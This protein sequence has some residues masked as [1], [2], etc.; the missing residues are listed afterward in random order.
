VNETILE[1]LAN[2][3]VVPWYALR[4]KSNFEKVSATLLTERG[5]EVF[6][7]T[8]HSRRTWSD[9]VVHLDLPLFPGYV[10][11]RVPMQNRVKVLSTP[12]VVSL[13][14][15]GKAPTAIE[16]S[17]IAAVRVL[18]NSKLSTQPWPFLQIGQRVRITRG[19]LSGVEG[20]LVEFKS[21]YRLVV[22]VSLLQRSVATEVDGSLVQPVGTVLARAAGVA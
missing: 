9:R 1:E 16:E 6:L 17:E 5:L 11:C 15:I 7:P 22:S 19:P 18:V 3:P 21:G 4:V 13:V 10:F 12:G 2:K 8:Y 14:G 20:N